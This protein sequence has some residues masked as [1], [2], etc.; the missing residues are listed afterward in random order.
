M[1][2]KLR[3]RG[4]KEWLDFFR[5]RLVLVGARAVGL[6]D[7]HVTSFTRRHPTPGVEIQATILANALERSSIRPRMPKA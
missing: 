3:G 5:D 6:G 1:P 2:G 4:R 7:T